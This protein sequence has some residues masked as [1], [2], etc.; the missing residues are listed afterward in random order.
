MEERRAIVHPVWVRVTHWINAFA[1]VIMV[2]SGLRIYDASPFLGFSVMSQFTL[3]GWLGGALLW[4]FAAVWLVVGNGLVYLACNIGTGRAWRKFL[5]VS[6]A[7]LQSDLRAVFH[8]SLSHADLSVYNSLQRIAYLFVWL[9]T[10]VLVLSGLVLFKSVQFP[11]LRELMGG[12]EAARRIHFFAMA[13]LLG[14][15]AVHVVMVILVPR[16][17]VAML[18]GR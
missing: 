4:H 18:R 11:L 1:V 7:A 13:G 5:P 15:V 6:P 16:S 17:L 12:Y 8:L 2:L 3:G 14:F 9:D 10:L